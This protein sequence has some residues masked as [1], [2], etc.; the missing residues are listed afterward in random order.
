MPHYPQV[1]KLSDEFG[2]Y[3]L[4]ITC[5]RCRNVRLIWPHEI[6]RKTGWNITLEQLQKRLR[7]IHCRA[8]DSVIDVMMPS[9]RK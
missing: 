6:A 3:K 5:A 7:C 2:E 8:K 9:N 4:R 1:R